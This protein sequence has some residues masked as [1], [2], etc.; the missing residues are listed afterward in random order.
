MIGNTNV[1]IEMVT[2]AMDTT[3]KQ[4]RD[5]AIQFKGKMFSLAVL[6]I[7][8]NDL[9]SIQRQLEHLIAQAPKMF[10]YAPVVIDLELANQLDIGIEL[11]AL[12]K[13]L[14]QHLVI[15]VGI[16]GG[17]PLQQQAA[18]KAG[19]ALFPVSK[20]AR[21]VNPKPVVAPAA[22]TKAAVVASKTKVISQPI[23]SGQQIYVKDGDLIVLASV[24]HG[25]EIIA[26]GNIHVYGS[27]H[28][29]AIAGANGDMNAR[30]FCTKL[31]AELVSIAGIYSLSDDYAAKKSDTPKQ[32]FLES[33]RLLITEL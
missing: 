32:I 18:A 29:R 6:H 28:G 13:L 25:A 5:T 26:D 1:K 2:R 20:N 22:S 23:R 24:S 19:L 33:D 7:Q 14:R 17:S 3:I 4:E 10:H 31:D 15:P 21:T 9:E 8:S 11:S 30:I 27:L 12:C 16:V